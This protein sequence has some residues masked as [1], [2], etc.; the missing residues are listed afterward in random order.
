[1]ASLTALKQHSSSQSLRPAPSPAVR[2]A[3]NS[4]ALTLDNASSKGRN[5]ALAPAACSTAAEVSSFERT[6]SI[7]RASALGT[8]FAVHRPADG[9]IVT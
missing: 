7:L 5:V 2:I 1:M 4:C 6:E 8:G 9:R 3:F